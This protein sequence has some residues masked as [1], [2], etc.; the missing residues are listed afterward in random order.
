M[1][2]VDVRRV[3]FPYLLEVLVALFEQLQEVI[4]LLDLGV[5]AQRRSKG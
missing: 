2:V 4:D 3:E 5:R 1:G